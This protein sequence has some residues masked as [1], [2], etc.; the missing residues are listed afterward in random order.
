MA[1]NAE[2][3]RRR[4][5]SP[6]LIRQDA[7]GVLKD[8]CHVASEQPEG[9]FLQECVLRTLEHRR[10]FN[11]SGQI[12]DAL[13]RQVGLFPY[14]SPE[15]IGIRDR[16]ALEAFR[17]PNLGNIVFH[18]PQARVYWTLIAGDNVV[19]S[20]PTSF[21]KSLIIDAI[22]ASERHKDILIV[23]P[24]IALI[25]ETRR[26]LSER[27]R[28]KYK[29]I[30]HAFQDPGR[31][32]VYVLTQ[33]RALEMVQLDKVDFFVIDEF[34][35]LTPRKD[36]DDDRCARLN[37]V[38]YR[39]IKTGKQ[40]YMLGPNILGLA[41]DLNTRFRCTTFIEPYRTVVSQLHDMRGK[42]DDWS[43][44]VGLCKT[45]KE[46]TIIFCSSPAR[47]TRV[48]QELISSKATSQPATEV[49]EAAD[50]IGGNYHPD[51]HF[52]K[53]LRAGIGIHHGRIPRAI[54]QYILRAFNKGQILFLICTSTL[55][56][57]VNTRAKNIIIFDEKIDKSRID[58]F[59]FNNI[60]GRSGRMG[61]HFIGNVYLFHEPPET[62]LP[63][64]DVPAFSQSE[65]TPESLLMQI[66]EVDLTKRSKERLKVF[67]E[68][69]ALDYATL[70]MN[71]ID[72]KAQI[73]LAREI[74]SDPAA[75][76]RTLNWTGMPTQP[77]LLGVCTLI[78][79]H[80]NGPRLGQRSVFSAKQLAYFIG[81]LRDRPAISQLIREQNEF[82]GDVDKAVQQILDFLRLWA[83]FHFPRLLR[84]VGRIQKDVFS[85]RDLP[86]GDYEV[87]AGQVENL[88]LDPTLIAL[89][90]YGIP[91]QVSLKLGR[92]LRPSGNLDEVLRN[93]K[94]LDPEGT[95]LTQFEKSLVREAQA[96]L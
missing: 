29:V 66:D 35:K 47:A 11:S 89:D 46:P 32:N 31:R 27:F 42:G 7:F 78:W 60:R 37:E 53:A 15:R 13:V 55:I 21:G 87:F 81:R 41:Q 65:E 44:L 86:F 77:Q 3:L 36:Y 12:I 40:F 63:L 38:F 10:L 26:R 58:L 2:E 16:L 30:T 92:H 22:I 8:V 84:T 68:Q 91:I 67:S 19:L 95:R 52:T 51:W 39:I 76:L 9:E 45:L 34:Y 80:F 62:E 70:K 43:R 88:F 49:N 50:W 90:E 4:L 1:V 74:G 69:Q 57:G 23:V 48:A 82:L 96:F 24:T 59:T 28:N 18:R 73:N 61:Q 75:F 5:S 20:A 14:L 6:S 17:P 56:E 72:P 79:K 25:D 64:V 85:R 33:E 94:A 93:L 71:D 54:G 83:G